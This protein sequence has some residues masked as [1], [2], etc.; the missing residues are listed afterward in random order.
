MKRILMVCLTA[1]VLL[2]ACGGTT[3]DQ[4]DTSPEREEVVTIYKSP[5]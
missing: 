2:T 3:T 4:Q 5:T 1:M